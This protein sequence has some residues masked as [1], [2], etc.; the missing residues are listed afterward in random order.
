MKHIVSTKILQD[1]LNYLA[2]R[3][4]TEVAA[5]IQTL[6]DDAKPIPEEENK[7]EATEN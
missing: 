7:Q 1:I 5:L 2:N 6:Q 3:P 4:Y